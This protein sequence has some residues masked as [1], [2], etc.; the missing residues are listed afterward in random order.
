MQGIV[1]TGE[2]E[3]RCIVTEVA[4]N[5]DRVAERQS[6]HYSHRKRNYSQSK[7]PRQAHN[8]KHVLQGVDG[9]VTQGETYRDQPVIS[10]YSKS[11]RL[12]S[13][14]S[15]VE[16]HLNQAQVEGNEIVLHQKYLYHAGNRA[17]VQDHVDHCQVDHG[18]K[19]WCVQTV[20]KGNDVDHQTV[21]ENRDHVDK[22]QE[23]EV[24]ADGRIRLK[25]NDVEARR[26]NDDRVV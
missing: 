21:E 16:K 26:M 13:P 25:S 18:Q 12:Q 1:I 5:S 4:E 6:I 9:V 17:R 2:S 10:K 22:G 23:D 7:A 24:E 3:H 19:L 20:V 15:I 14:K 11:T 8:T